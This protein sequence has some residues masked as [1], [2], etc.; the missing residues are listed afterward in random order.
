MYVGCGACAKEAV[1]LSATPSISLVSIAPSLVKE[2]SDSLVIEIA[3]EDGDGDLGGVHPDSTNLFVTDSRIGIVYAFRIQELVPGGA[4]VPIK[5]T[6]RIVLNGLFR[7]NDTAPKETV[8][9]EIV[10]RDKAGNRSNVLV[11]EEV[12][13]VE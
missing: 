6:F 10:A 2:F 3:Y 9:F 11:T 12:E 7:V 8:S 13:V 1:E 4:T 5:G